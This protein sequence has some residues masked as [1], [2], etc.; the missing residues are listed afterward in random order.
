MGLIRAPLCAR[1]WL[2]AMESDAG[3]SAA[4]GHRLSEAAIWRRALA[5]AALSVLTTIAVHLYIRVSYERRRRSG[6][7]SV[8]AKPAKS[9]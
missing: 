1:M 7:D 5:L 6:H 3:I 9:D 2:R 8:L 4:G